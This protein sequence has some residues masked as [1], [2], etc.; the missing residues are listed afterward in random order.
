MSLF[1]SWVRAYT[2][3]GDARASRQS[4]TDQ[5]ARGATA[6]RTL[7]LPVRRPQ[8]ERAASSAPGA[9]LLT[10]CECGCSA[11]VV[12]TTST[13]YI[14]PDIRF[15]K[16]KTINPSK[17]DNFC[18]KYLCKFCKY[19][20]VLK[21]F[22]CQ[23]GHVLCHWPSAVDSNCVARRA[24]GCRS[25][26]AAARQLYAVLILLQLPVLP[27]YLLYSLGYLHDIREGL[28]FPE[29]F[30]VINPKHLS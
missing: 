28:G 25:L 29:I 24:V 8:Y 14:L 12:L 15:V 20:N 18:L 11:C 27:L 30:T 5:S 23:Y 17:Y 6:T 13:L 22:V 1:T 2:R 4:P 16:G 3:R 9:V 21:W 26:V 7:P 10:E 19:L